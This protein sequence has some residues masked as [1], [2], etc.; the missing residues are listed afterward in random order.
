MKW[1]K[2]SINADWKACDAISGMLIDIGADGVEIEDPHDMVLVPGRHDISEITPANIDVFDASARVTVKAYFAES[3][4]SQELINIIKEK[5]KEITKQIDAGK[6]SLSFAKIDDRDWANEWKKHF[7]PFH[8]TSSIVI[9]PSWYGYRAQGEEKVVELDPGMAF[10][11]GKHETTRMCA[12]LIEKYMT[13][14]S[15][16]ADIGCG[17]GILS[18]IAVVLGAGLVDAVDIDQTAVTVAMENVRTNGVEDR[19]SIKKGGIE[20]L[21]GKYDFIT[22]NIT[23]D[24]LIDLSGKLP[25]Y[26]E[27]GGSVAASGIL[28]DREQDVIQAFKSSGFTVTDKIAENNWVAILFSKNR[29]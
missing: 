11:T 22:A 8:I 19:I 2:V 24:V 9:K 26:L 20:E 6:W 27:K 5:M 10:G 1:T 16:V 14:A 18:I 25:F 17:S 23:A 21:S 13:A 15:K 12:L 28:N 4:C 29:F 7:R 3:V